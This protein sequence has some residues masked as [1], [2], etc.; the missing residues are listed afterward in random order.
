[1]RGYLKIILTL[2]RQAGKTAASVQTRRMGAALA[3]Y[4]LFALAPLFVIMLA[5]AGVWFGEEAARQ[6]L[7]SRISGL[8]GTAAGEAIQAVVGA[9]YRERSGGWAAL[10]ASAVLFI[11]ATGVFVQLRGSLNTIWGVERRPG[12][13]WGHLITDRLLSFVFIQAMALILLG[14]LILSAG[15]SAVDEFM[16]EPLQRQQ[17]VWRGIHYLVSFGVITLMFALMFKVLPSV[18]IAWGDVWLGAIIT[19]LLFNLGKFLFGKYL[20]WSGVS[21]AFGAAGSLVITLLWVYYS[22]Q[23][24]LFGAKFTQLYAEALG[25]RR[26]LAASGEKSRAKTQSPP[27][28]DR[29]APQ[30]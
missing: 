27:R 13:G 8:V 6:E 17:L 16:G 4:T 3:F 26:G 9:A 23:I 11:N 15:L 25:S 10:I 30:S 24:L 20:A 29:P 28:G 14:S 19:T 18:R 1:M 7:S 2:G 5:L 22:A 12:H 21:S